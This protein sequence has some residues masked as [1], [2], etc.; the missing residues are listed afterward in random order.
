[1]VFEKRRKV[2]LNPFSPW[3]NPAESLQQTL[4]GRDFIIKNILDKTRRFAEGAR[5]KH[6]LLIGRR[7]NK[8]LAWHQIPQIPSWKR[9][10][11]KCSLKSVRLYF[12]YCREI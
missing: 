1:M 4:V 8:K 2:S 6:C 12:R 11:K 9:R 5:A 3:R 7:C 10:W